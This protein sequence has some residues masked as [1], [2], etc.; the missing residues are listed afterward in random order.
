[1]SRAVRTALGASRG[2]LTRQML[3]E[4]ALLA[5]IG[6]LGGVLVAIGGLRVLGPLIPQVQI[7]RRLTM[8]LWLPEATYGSPSNVSAFYREVL[9][10]VNQY[11][12]VRAAAV[13]NTRPFLGWSLGAT[14]DIPGRPAQPNGEDTIVGFRIISP[15]YLLALGTSLVRGRGFSDSDGPESGGTVLINEVMARRF[16]PTENP[17]GRIIRVKPLGS[18]SVAPW[19]PAQATDTFTIVGV[20]GNIR[21]S[22]LTDQVGP[23]VYLSYLQN[24]SRY[25][26]LL[27]RTASAPTN[28]TN[29]V[30]REIRAVDADLGVYD[31]QPMEAVLTQAVAEPRLNALLLWV[32]A[33]LALLLSAVG[34]YGV[35]SYAVAQRTREFAIRLAIGADAQSL[36][37]MVTREALAVAF[38]GISLG[39][40]G[41]WLLARTLTSL[42]YG[43][44]PTDGSILSGGA[45]VVLVV[46]LLACWRPA[47]RATRVD[48]V[49]VLRAE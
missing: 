16:W 42:L 36:F 14:V 47:W 37:R 39:L 28:A 49:T 8:Q 17:I 9:R 3:T 27:V 15:G 48:P 34:V 31:V 44:V 23:V 1:M 22:R 19:W 4:S 30:Q 7:A 18:T 29:L 35:T 2:R 13:V 33:T 26:H 41:A 6:A 24:A 46:A 45:S 38:V 40:G 21:E 10:R 43:V 11:P 20:V 25:A 32:F 5:G 12:E